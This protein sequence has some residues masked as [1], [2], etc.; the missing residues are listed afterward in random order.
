MKYP[1]DELFKRIENSKK[2]KKSLTHITDKTSLSTE[3]KMKLSLC[4]HFVQYANEKKI[5][6]SDLSK[7]TGI[8]SSRLSEIVNYKI[9]KF[10]VDQLIKNLNILAQFAPRIR[11]YLLFIEQAVDVPMLKVGETRKLT[12]GL[13]EV[14]QL[15]SQ[16]T[17]L[18]V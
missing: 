10:S 15:G 17:F 14:T 2:L 7:Q 6:L 13:R 1:N 11:E 5:K 4:K 18:H 12:K 3:E 8:P 9:N 16:S